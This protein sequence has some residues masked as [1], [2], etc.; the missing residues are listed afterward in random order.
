VLRSGGLLV[1]VSV[2]ERARPS[3]SKAASGER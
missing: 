1:V 3:G 2:E